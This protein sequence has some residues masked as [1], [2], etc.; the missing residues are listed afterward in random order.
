MLTAGRDRRPADSL[1]P[2]PSLP[3]QRDADLTRRKAPAR[4]TAHRSLRARDDE[5]AGGGLRRGYAQ[6]GLTSNTAIIP[7]STHSAMWQWYR[8]RP[9]IV[10]RRHREV[11]VAPVQ[12]D[13]VAPGAQRLQAAVA[14]SPGNASHA[15]ERATRV[16]ARESGSLDFRVSV[17]HTASFA[18]SASCWPRLFGDA[19]P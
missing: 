14:R 3:D 19:R 13:H 5:A 8:G 4:R 9:P 17:D 7:L 6:S 12:V 2:L 1:V 18:H 11:A 16:A 15:G 10:G